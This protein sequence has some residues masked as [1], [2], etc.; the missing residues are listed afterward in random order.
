MAFGG[1]PFDVTYGLTSG[2]TIINNVSL[3]TSEMFCPNEINYPRT[4]LVLYSTDKLLII[5]KQRHLK[6]LLLTSDG[7]FSNPDGL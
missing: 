6:I 1:H 2:G 4:L 7:S 5:L 3:L